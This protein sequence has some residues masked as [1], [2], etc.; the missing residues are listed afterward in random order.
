M[1]LYGYD[2]NLNTGALPE[3]RDFHKTLRLAGNIQTVIT[4]DKDSL[5]NT[6]SYTANDGS[7][8]EVWFLDAVSAWDQYLLAKQKK[9]HGTSLSYDP[10]EDTSV[11]KFFHPGSLDSISI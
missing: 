1:G 9:F 6:F 7:N 2:W 11:W 3:Q 8:H 10:N 4:W 5:N